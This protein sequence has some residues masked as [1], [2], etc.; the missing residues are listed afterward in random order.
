MHRILYNPRGELR[1]GWKVLGFVLLLVVVGKGLSLVARAVPIVGT[2]LRRSGAWSEAA[3]GAAVSALCLVLE[4]RHPL[5]F[6]LRFN[7]RWLVE[8]LAGAGGGVLLLV[9]I[10]LAVRGTGAF[11]WVRDPAIGPWQLVSWLGFYLGVGFNEEILVRGYVFQ[12]LARGGLGVAGTQLLLALFF[13]AGH[14]GNPNNEGVYRAW[15]TL[16]IALAALLLGFA[17]LRTGSLAL[18]IGI[19]LGWNW[20]QGTLLGFNVS[21]TTSPGWWSPVLDP[22]RPAWVHGGAFGLEATLACAILCGL[23]IL[24]LAW[25]KGT[26]ARMEA[27]PEHP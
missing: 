15:A 23:A 20:T 7:R 11:H 21:G 12:R 5:D 4:G 10:A 14:W 13:A 26:A 25:W 17:M 24:L 2:L 27:R 19:H 22:A 18:P 6:G 8:F 9:A 3:V 16:N 1:S